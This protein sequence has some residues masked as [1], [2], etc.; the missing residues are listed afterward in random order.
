ML[1]Q[2]APIRWPPVG[3]NLMLAVNWKIVSG[4]GATGAKCACPHLT[5]SLTLPTFMYTRI[6]G[7]LSHH[8]LHVNG[9]FLSKTA[10]SEIY[11]QD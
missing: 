6:K 5:P 7:T 9:A 2:L 4:S 11:M 8:R 10:K 1:N 3:Q